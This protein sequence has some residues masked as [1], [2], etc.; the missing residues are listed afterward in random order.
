MSKLL[1]HQSCKDT[2]CWYGGK[3]RIVTQNAQ[4]GNI[5]RLKAE[6]KR[7]EKIF[8]DVDFQGMENIA[9]C[10]DQY[11][12]DY[13]AR[14]LVLCDDVFPGPEKVWVPCH[15]VSSLAIEKIPLW[16]RNFCKKL[17]R[18]FEKNTRV[19][20]YIRGAE[21]LDDCKMGEDCQALNNFLKQ[22]QDKLKPAQKD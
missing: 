21:D 12:L 1:G 11:G 5:K 13:E 10:F 22:H 20:R 18:F 14:I 3:F 15:P 17:C 6:K 7:L 19:C 2:V 8:S 16:L 4:A 9:I